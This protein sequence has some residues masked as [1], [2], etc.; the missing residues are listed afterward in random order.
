MHGIHR[1]VPF[2]GRHASKGVA[3]RRSQERAI[4]VKMR[5]GISVAFGLLACCLAGQPC[6]QAQ[7]PA[8]VPAQPAENKQADGQ[9]PPATS[10]KVTDSNPFPEDTTSVPVMPNATAPAAAAPAWDGTSPDNVRVPG[11][12]SDPVR[13]PDDVTADSS[14]SR[15]EDSSSNFTNLEKIIAPPDNDSKRKKGDKPPEPVETAADDENVGG[16]YLSTKNW[17]AALSRYQ[18]ALVLDPENPEVYWGLAE[19]QRHL[20]D[21]A[22]AKANYLKLLDYD[23]DGKHGKEARKAL[24][25]PELAN[26]PTASTAPPPP[27]P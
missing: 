3:K 13:S 9:K 18:S 21:L 22:N 10:P 25:D 11:E 24:K 20:G 26:A 23:P 6:L 8:N 7:K 17:K 27:H 16:Y 19:A 4:R 15:S 1:I 12:D 2:K 14:S 5:I